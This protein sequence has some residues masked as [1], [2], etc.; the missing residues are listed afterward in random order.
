[1]NPARGGAVARA[2]THFDSGDFVDVFGAGKYESGE[3]ARWSEGDWNGDE[4]FDSGDFIAAFQDGG[5]E[6]GARTAVASVP[7]PASWILLTLGLISVGRIR[8]R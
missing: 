8:R 5:Y 4:L 1:M 7:E 6:L 2:A 3:L